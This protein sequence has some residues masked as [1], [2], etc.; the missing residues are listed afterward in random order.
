MRII[1]I[2]DEPLALEIIKK[3]CS[4][5]ETIDLVGTFT[6]A[7]EAIEVINSKNVDLVFIDVEMPNITGLEFVKS[8]ESPPLFILTTA[9]RKYAMDGYELNALDYL[10]KPIALDKFLKAIG[11]AAKHL[12]MRDNKS[13][14]SYSGEQEKKDQYL[15]VKVDYST[16][17]VNF[18]DINFVEGLKDYL[19]I[20]TKDSY[21]ITKS[22]IKH[23]ES[24]L[25][26]ETFQRVHKSYIISF[27]HIDK[28]E[29]NRIFIGKNKIPIG[30]QYKDSFYDRIA[31]LK[32]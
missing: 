1:A 16:V 20:H 24:K 21:L 23:L 29:N 26:P 2:D 7:F 17:R 18:C 25:P 15:F 6:N 9:H 10:L 5:L 3:Y 14:N 31:E 12:S 19:K 8:L 13:T 27:D 30:L 32:L 11:K 22:T 4:N 28:I